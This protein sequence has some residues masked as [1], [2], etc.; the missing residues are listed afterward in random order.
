M[1]S[2]ASSH[3]WRLSVGRGLAVAIVFGAL[4]FGQVASAQVSNF[5]VTVNGVSSAAGTYNSANIF[6]ATCEGTETTN[7]TAGDP[8]IFRLQWTVQSDDTI[9]W[10]TAADCTTG[11]TVTDDAGAVISGNDVTGPITIQPAGADSAQGYGVGAGNVEINM[12]TVFASAF[13]KIYGDV[14]DGGNPCS[15]PEQGTLYVCVT[16]QETSISTIASNTQT[17]LSWYM[18]VTYDTATPE[19]PSGVTGQSGDSNVDV[20]WTFDDTNFPGQDI[21]FNVYYQPDPDGLVPDLNGGCVAPSAIGDAGPAES[22]RSIWQTWAGDPPDAGD[23]GCPMSDQDSFGDCCGDAGVTDG[24]CNAV[25]AGPGINTPGV[26]GG[27]FVDGDCGGNNACVQDDFGN[28]YC[29]A[30]CTQGDNLDGGGNLDCPDGFAC[31]EKPDVQG[32]LESYVC[33]PPSNLCIPA[34]VACGACGSNADCPSGECVDAGATYCAVVCTSGVNADGDGACLGATSCQSVVGENELPNNLCALPS[35]DCYDPTLLRVV[36]DGGDQFATDAGSVAVDAGAGGSG[37][38]TSGWQVQQFSGTLSTGQIGGLTN[39][40]CYDFVVQT[41]V[42]DG[43]LGN[44]S[45][46]VVVAPIKN[47]DFWRLYQL[48]GGGDGGGLHCQAGGGAVGVLGA[49]A[50]LIGWRRRRHPEPRE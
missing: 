17:T 1:L 5:S 36:I 22:G 20:S 16:Q 35:L 2:L 25:D 6:Q 39:G 13:P 31:G 49:L 45:S 14:F 4:V 41:V 40:T 24:T 44:N 43:T 23:A 46:E 37:I 33:A 15:P 42:D 11:N 12:R 32:E 30:S 27:C 28:N 29:G 10:D 48:D 19:A 34:W 8:A 50:A 38:D 18:A 7:S 26:C 9:F 21:D 47:Y 3:A